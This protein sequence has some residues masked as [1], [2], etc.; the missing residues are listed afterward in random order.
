MLCCKGVPSPRRIQLCSGCIR[1]YS[2]FYFCYPSNKKLI[3]YDSKLSFTCRVR[4]AT[5]L[6]HKMF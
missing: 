2:I 4:Y 1:Y 6:I 3:W 5:L